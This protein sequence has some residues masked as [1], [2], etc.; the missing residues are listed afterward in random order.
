MKN[1]RDPNVKNERIRNL[2]FNL[3]NQLKLILR[4][5]PGNKMSLELTRQEAR[6]L[7]FVLFNFVDIWQ[8]LRHKTNL[9]LKVRDHASKN[10]WGLAHVLLALTSK[11]KRGRKYD[12]AILLADF[13]YA[14]SKKGL[15][16]SNQRAYEWLGKNHSKYP[17]SADTARK[18]VKSALTWKETPDSK[19]ENK[20][21]S[22]PMKIK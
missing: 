10:E 2:A 15:G 3:Q 6:M 14:I 19:A 4:E 8:D 9:I 7:K 5:I 21:K 17:M 22:S 20:N 13:E 1:K 16:L 11:E 18:A 12:Y